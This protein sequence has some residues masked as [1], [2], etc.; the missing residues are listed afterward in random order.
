MRDLHLNILYIMLYR[1]KSLIYV[2]IYLFVYTRT[3]I[4]FTKKKNGN[5][6]NDCWQTVAHALQLF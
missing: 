4:F 5:R 2:I 1:L 3:G 6:R